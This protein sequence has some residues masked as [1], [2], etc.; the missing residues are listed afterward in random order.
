MSWKDILVFADGSRNGLAR[1][2]MAADLATTIG[3]NLEV[4]IPVCLPPLSASGG[5]EFAA[6]LYDELERSARDDAHRASV[7]LRSQFPDLAGRLEIHTPE[8]RMPDIP[9]LV[10]SLGQASDLIVVGQPIDED[11]TR[12]DD[13]LLDGAL[14]RSGRPCLMLPRWDAAHV[15]GKKILIAWKDIPQAARAV[16]DAIPLLQ[17]A[18]TVGIVT[19]HHGAHPERPLQ[20]SVERLQR[21]LGRF[22]V[23]AVPHTVLSGGSDDEA[24]LDQAAIWGADLLVMGGYGHSRLREFVLGGVTRTAIQKST[25][26]VLLS[27]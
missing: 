16:G 1:A 13:A 14:F 9:K 22:G 21:H 7:E 15:F 24:I 23:Q 26:P 3:A 25:I 8:A 18:E 19:I 2:R 4:C 5:V 11:G 27:H 17:R 12:T 10:G 20:R 6:E